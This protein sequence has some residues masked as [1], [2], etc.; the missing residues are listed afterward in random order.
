MKNKYIN[1]KYTYLCIKHTQGTVNTQHWCL[2][3]PTATSLA[4]IQ[5]RTASETHWTQWHS[6]LLM[7]FVVCSKE[8]V[9]V[10]SVTWGIF[11][12][13]DAWVPTLDIPEH[14]FHCMGKMQKQGR[15]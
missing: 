8:T 14:G 9:F 7:V 10:M 12:E 11:C 3:G 2:L 1:I 15:L 4:L 5:I 6:T 13:T